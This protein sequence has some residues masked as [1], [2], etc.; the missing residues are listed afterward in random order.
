M[1][2]HTK[3]LDGAGRT[4]KAG[5]IVTRAEDGKTYVLLI[6]RPK[7]ADWQYPKGHMDQGETP[8]QAAVREVEEECGIQV[9]IVSPLPTLEYTT[10]EQEQVLC[11]M[12]RMRPLSVE[13]NEIRDEH[14]E[15]VP[16]EKVIESLSHDNLKEYFKQVSPLL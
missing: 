8:E 7:H 1:S 4:L 2:T 6:Y 14:P 16:L 5:G 3:V 9:E 12:Y 10:K 13:F 15:W 11:Y